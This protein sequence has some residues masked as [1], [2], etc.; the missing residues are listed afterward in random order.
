MLESPSLDALMSYAFECAPNGAVI[1]DSDGIILRINAEIEHCFGYARQELLGKSIEILLPERYRLAHM[2]QRLSFISEGQARMMGARRNLSARRK[3]GVEFP[4][5]VGLNPMTT[6]QGVVILASIIDI[7]AR[8]AEEAALRESEERLRAVLENVVDGVLTIDEQGIMQSVNPAAERIFGYRAAE[9]LG[10]NIAILMPEPY[11]SQHDGYLANYRRTGDAKII[12]IGREV[13][14]RRKD[15]STFP[16]DLAVS[17]FHL[18]GARAFAGLVRDITARKAA[19]AQIKFYAEALQ[20][21]NTELQRS[22]QELDDFAYIASHDLKEPLRGIHNY[23]SFLIEDYAD[24]LDDDGRNKLET[25]KRLTQRL[26]DLIDSLLKFSRVGRLDLAVQETDLSDVI[27]AVQ[28]S[29]AINLRERGVELRVPRPLPSVRCDSVRIGEVFRNLIVNAMKYNDKPVKWIE[30]GYV[31]AQP[32]DGEQSDR[33]KTTFY[34]R[35]NGIGIP[36]KHLDAV[37][38]I[39]KRLHSR[40]KFG[41]G[42]GVGL[43]IVKKIVERHGGRIWIDSQFGEGSSFNF[44]LGSET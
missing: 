11:H 28:D 16:M 40:D 9:L 13:T 25:I 6:Q 14:G 31:G 1:V 27:A 30:V 2:A 26:E 44:T 37:F 36:K 3:D 38:R 24:K 43:P 39:F 17:S 33:G 35:D 41:G 19:E 10:R 21:Q 34:V 4:V 42:T 32:L 20:A 29:L 15:G 18:A 5:E 8:A 22:N 12:G 23:S 7:S